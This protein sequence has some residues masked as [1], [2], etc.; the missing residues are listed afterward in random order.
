LQDL[1]YIQLK[2]IFQDV[3]TPFS[4]LFLD[5]LDHNIQTALSRSQKLNIRLATKSIRS[6][7]VLEYLQEHLGDRFCGLMTY[8]L[9]ESLYLLKVG[10]DH[11]L[12][13]YPQ[14]LTIS[15][16]KE[17]KVLSEQNK[18]LV[19]MIDS[20]EHINDLE[21]IGE[22][23]KHVFEV[24]VDI[25]L[26]LKLPGL[27]F[28]VYRSPLNNLEKCQQIFDRLKDSKWIKCVGMMGYEAQLAGVADYSVKNKIF[29]LIVQ[30]LKRTSM[31]KCF[32]YRQEAVRLAKEYFSLEF[33]NGG[34]TGSLSATA[35]DSSVT[36]VTIGSGFYC[37]HLF[38]RYEERFL[39][40]CGYAVGI[41]RKP[42]AGMITCHGGGYV[43][44]GAFGVDK[45]PQVFSPKQLDFID[46][47]M[48]GEVQTPFQ[49]SG[50]ENFEI[51]DP[52]FLRH[53]KAGELLERFNQL[54]IVRDNQ[55]IDQWNTYRGDGLCFL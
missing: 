49:Y 47:E 55:M 3:P 35:T 45:I 32:H 48:F 7:K 11:C 9:D 36:E 23:L 44:S 54:L 27:N 22:K 30:K 20:V 51:G 50:D 18:K 41:S 39:P 14:K 29:D 5:S 12:M 52:I 8:H 37:P 1:S 16:A 26:S 28:G 17:I 15:E 2:S 43:A 24:C 13:G 25:D 21:Q 38:D 4:Y 10:F 6:I 42:A 40:S 46:N 19:Q 33:V 34:G 31:P 53:A